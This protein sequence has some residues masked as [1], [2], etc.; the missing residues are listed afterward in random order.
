MSTFSNTVRRGRLLRIPK[1]GICLLALACLVPLG[2][3]QAQSA[4]RSG[5]PAVPQYLYV[6]DKGGEVKALQEKLQELGYYDG[7]VTG[8]F[9]QQTLA[10]VKRF[11]AEHRLPANGYYGPVTRAKLAELLEKK[12]DKNKP[13]ARAPS[14]AVPATPP[15][16]RVVPPSSEKPQVPPSTALSSSSAVAEQAAGR[17]ALTFDDGPDMEATP[18]LLQV[19]KEK[20][21]RATFFVVGREAAARPGLLRGIAEA[22]HEV[23]N[24]SYSHRDFT[25]LSARERR[26]EISRTARLIKD[27]TGRET[28][29]FRP[30]YGAFAPFIFT[31]ANAVRHR[32]A[33]WTNIGASDTLSLPAEELVRR[34]AASARDGAVIMLHNRR[35][36][37]ALLPA[38]IDALRAGGFRLVTLAELLKP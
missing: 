3:V 27:L 29:F 19:L 28:V 21:V 15:R 10:A 38:L 25:T 31:E 12:R 1:W 11:Q 8:F 18:F 17:L 37:A 4:K 20:G 5:A 34:L 35:E 26:D 13:A 9:G 22:G 7:P 36:T 24:H 32:V 23:E 16:A 2:F 30:P 33:L 14:G 6:G